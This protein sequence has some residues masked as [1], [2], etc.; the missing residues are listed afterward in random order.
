MKENIQNLIKN[1]IYENAVK[2]K[3]QASQV[4]YSKVG[5]RLKQ[6]YINVSKSMFKNINEDAY[7][8]DAYYEI[9]AA[10]PGRGTGGSGTGPGNND[11]PGGPTRGIQ[12]GVPPE[13][14]DPGPAP[15]KPEKGKDETAE[16]FLERLNQYYELYRQW[17]EQYEAFKKYRAWQQGL[18]RRKNQ[19][20]YKPSNG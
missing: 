16:E 11:N 2:F 20:G 10:G 9:M 15:K 4:L 8:I 17:K 3:D 12:Y 14:K 18:G 19:P 1:A 5:D 7:G 6:E 13:A